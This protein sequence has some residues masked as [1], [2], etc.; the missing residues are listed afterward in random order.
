MG[1]G[2][3]TQMTYSVHPSERRVWNALIIVV[4][5]ILSIQGSSR[6][7]YSILTA[8][9]HTHR[10]TGLQ[11]TTA[12]QS[13]IVH[14]GVELSTLEALPLPMWIAHNGCFRYVNPMFSKLTGYATSDLVGQ[15]HLS[16]LVA[17]HDQARI[18]M[19]FSGDAASSDHQTIDVRCKRR[20][21][22]WFDSLLQGRAI[23]TP[24]GTMHVGTLSDVTERKRLESQLH[25]AQRLELLGQLSGGVIHDCNHLLG[26]IIGSSACL[27]DEQEDLPATLRQNLDQIHETGLRAAKLT[28]QVVGI[29]KDTDAEEA[30]TDV[31]AVLYELQGLFHA[32]LSTSV[33]IHIC[34]QARHNE[35]SL[36]PIQLQQIILNLVINAR[37]AMPKGGHLKLMVDN[38]TM[39][40][41]GKSTQR[42][43]RLEISDT[44]C[45]MDAETQ[46]RIFQPF[47]TTKG[48]KGGTGLGL[49]AVQAIMAESGGHIQVMSTLGKGTT[50][51]LLFP[52]N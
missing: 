1:Q 26:V 6:A 41:P 7:L 16:D 14:P 52:Q 31:S 25:K 15:R 5:S 17:P 44:G 10:R 4:G 43:L 12:P 42:F 45:G 33:S 51:S 35:I 23:H 34:S 13:P 50:F 3:S 9:F 8:R 11:P 29:S 30:T 47:F 46:A 20:D 22:T 27:L 28:R 18:T 2:N 32:L 36:N 49:A 19:L 48:T 39:A 21:G 38:V 37:D 24:Q 40:I